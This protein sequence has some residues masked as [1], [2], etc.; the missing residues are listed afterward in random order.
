MPTI[1]EMRFKYPW[2]PDMGEISGFGGSYEDACRKMVW[3]GLAWLE[4]K[5]GADLKASTYRNIYGILKP[6]DAKEL[7]EA[8][9]AACPDC[10][11]AMHQATMSICLYVAKRGWAAFV[12]AKREG[13]SKRT[14]TGR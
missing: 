7:S 13:A 4:L 6:D 10:S 5:P 1:E 2:T 8:I 3:A 11:G 9:C 14:G 12:E